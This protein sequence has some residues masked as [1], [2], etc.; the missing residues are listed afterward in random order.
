MLEEVR[1][2]VRLFDGLILDA[3]LVIIVVVDHVEFLLIALLDG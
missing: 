2:I 3:G 1:D